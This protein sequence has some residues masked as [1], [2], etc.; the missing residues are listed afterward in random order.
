ML[1]DIVALR[2]DQ[3]KVMR[4]DAGRVLLQQTVELGLPRQVALAV[5]RGP[6]RRPLG[7][8]ARGLQAWRPRV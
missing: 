7:L 2:G 3:L 8:P 1:A 6:V 5:K 4:D